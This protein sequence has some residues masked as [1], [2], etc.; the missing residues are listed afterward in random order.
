M[1]RIIKAA[2]ELMNDLCQGCKKPACDS[3]DYCRK[4]KRLRETIEKDRNIFDIEIKRMV[5]ILQKLENSGISAVVAYGYED[6]KRIEK[7]EKFI[8]MP[9]EYKIKD[10][11]EHYQRLLEEVLNINMLWRGSNE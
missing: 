1:K 2:E 3:I 9:R 10:L 8:A 11:I 4:V 6:H 5:D 7:G